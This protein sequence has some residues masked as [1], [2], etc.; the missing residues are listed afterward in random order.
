M[1]E[2][3]TP[4]ASLPPPDIVLLVEDQDSHEIRNVTLV[5]GENCKPHVPEG[6]RGSLSFAS[7]FLS[8][9]L[10]LIYWSFSIN[11]EH[12]KHHWS[13]GKG[14]RAEAS[15][16]Q[17]L[18]VQQVCLHENQKSHDPCRLCN[19]DNRLHSLVRST[20]SARFPCSW[21]LHLFPSP[22]FAICAIPLILRSQHIVVH[23]CPL[24]KNRLGSSSWV[25]STDP[26]ECCR[27][28]CSKLISSSSH[29]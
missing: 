13:E 6:R 11:F 24:C 18:E 26:T 17:V 5:V 14:V 19:I 22:L 4:R 15:R 1:A 28:A 20:F 12:I 8:S 9:W 23:K 27:V 2:R 25:T 21:S 16:S 3:A 29:G 10:S 7:W